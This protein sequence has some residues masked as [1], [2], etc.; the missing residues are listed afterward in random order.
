MFFLFFSGF[1]TLSEN[2]KNL[3]GLKES[4]DT[5]LDLKDVKFRAH[6]TV[7]MAR[8]SVFSAMFQH[9]TSEKQTGIITIPDCDPD[10][11]R[12][13]LKYLYCGKIKLR[14]YQSATRLYQISDKYDVQELKTFC[15]EYLIE[16]LRREG[17]FCDAVIFADRYNEPKLLSGCQNIFNEFFNDIVKT[18]EWEC[19]MDN[20][21]RLASKLL[22]NMPKIRIIDEL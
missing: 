22:K 7:L 19:L 17:D 16:N 2:F 9:E 11:F 8:S 1:D 14:T 18:T 3:F 20:N 5:T 6:R 21:Y 10:S 15:R 12:K 13:F 4:C